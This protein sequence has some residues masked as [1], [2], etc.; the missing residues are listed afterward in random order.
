MASKVLATKKVSVPTLV[1]MDG[2]NSA[3]MVRS[4]PVTHWV[5]VAHAFEMA[6]GPESSKQALHK[7]LKNLDD[8][9]CPGHGSSEQ[10]V[11]LSSFSRVRWKDRP[12]GKTRGGHES[13]IAPLRVVVQLLMTINSGK[14]KVARAQSV[15]TC[16][17]LTQSLAQKADECDAAQARIAT[18]E[19]SAESARREA[20]LTTKVDQL[21]SRL[22]ELKDAEVVAEDDMCL[23]QL[24]VLYRRIGAEWHTREQFQALY[25]GQYREVREQ[26]VGMMAVSRA[27]IIEWLR[28]HPIGKRF[29]LRLCDRCGLLHEPFDS[30]QFE[31]EHIHN[32]A[33][34]GADHFF[35]YMILPGNVNRSIEFRTGPCHLKMI[36]IGRTNFALVQ[37]F[38]RWHQ[39]TKQSVPRDAFIE[40]ECTNTT[41]SLL[42]GQMQT[43]LGF[44]R[45]RD[46]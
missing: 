22:R 14:T 34:G 23:A 7:L 36:M 8:N 29:W 5:D 46:A 38:A 39:S 2:Y 27:Q 30:T 16:L 42:G 33:W 31:I 28:S 11:D 24:K 6:L 45:M 18:L 12:G 44:K 37:S 25:L 17:E 4:D 21:E 43:T 13:I 3:L 35:N 41:V 40:S 32:A 15:T 9:P 10:P 26:F 19:A 1:P 20:E